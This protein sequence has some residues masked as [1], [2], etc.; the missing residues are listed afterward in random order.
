MGFSLKNPYLT[1]VGYYNGYN[2]NTIDTKSPAGCYDMAGN[3]M[4]WCGTDFM[5]IPYIVGGDYGSAGGFFLGY[6]FNDQ[7]RDYLYISLGL[8]LARTPEKQSDE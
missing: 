2:P 4:E 5:H 1:P 3:V 6:N 7:P 8:R